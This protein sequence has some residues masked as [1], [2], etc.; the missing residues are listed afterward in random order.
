MTLKLFMKISHILKKIHFY[1]KSIIIF[2][3]LVIGSLELIT[4]LNDFHHQ[5]YWILLAIIY[6][7]LI[8]EVFVHRIC[9]HNMFKIDTNSYLYKFL[10]WMSSSDMGY[11]PVIQSI[12]DHNLHH[13]Y[14]DKGPEDIMNWRYYW[15]CTTTMIPLPIKYVKPPNYYQYLEVQK[16]NYKNILEDKWTIFCANYQII[17]SI[18]TFAFIFLVFP[19]FLFKVVFVGRVLLSIMTGLAGFVGHVKN[20]PGNYRNYETDDTTSN[21]MFFHLLFLGFFGAMLQN[22]HHGRPRDENPNRKWWEIDSG[23]IFIKLLRIAMEVKP[24]YK[25][26]SA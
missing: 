22:N 5:W 1:I 18:I 8:N 7:T 2:L 26:I 3:M 9:S 13:I 16:N 19:A 11:G 20:F 15:Y 24:E 6:T 10:I 17:I 4:I 12:L 25:K 23:L 21:N 14:S